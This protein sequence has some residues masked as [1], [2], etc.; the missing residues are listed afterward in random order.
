[1]GFTPDPSSI[2]LNT[3][4]NFQLSFSSDTVT[5]AGST[6]V[7]LN[8]ELG[9]S[10]VFPIDSIYGLAFTMTFDTAIVDTVIY[11]VPGGF[12]AAGTALAE[13]GH[14]DMGTGQFHLAVTR[15]SQ[16][17]AAGAGT[18][19]V[20]GIV[21]DDNIRTS[22]TYELPIGISSVFGMTSNESHVNFHPVADTLTVI[23][24][25]NSISEGLK[26]PIKVYPNPAGQTLQI[27]A[28]DLDIDEINLIDIHGSVVWKE[29][30]QMLRRR[31]L[32]LQKFSPGVYFLHIR[33]GDSVLRKKLFFSQT[34]P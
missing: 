1:G 19:G 7:N 8:I 14:V 29:G 5:F 13:F 22:G 30:P 24:L 18:I 21:M 32:P 25:E 33:S 27:E 28:P 23:T 16:T 6:I 12:L 9:T 15:T 4:P 17:N 20:V 10:P 11:S 3:P 34:H 31:V 2:S 26:D